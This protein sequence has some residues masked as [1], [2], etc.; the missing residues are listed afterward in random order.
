MRNLIMGI[1]IGMLIG[2]GSV[3]VDNLLLQYATSYHPPE[4]EHYFEQ[5]GKNTKVLDVRFQAEGRPYGS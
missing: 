1:L 4:S 5:S 3:A 2:I